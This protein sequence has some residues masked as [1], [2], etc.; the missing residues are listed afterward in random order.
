MGVVTTRR[1]D[2]LR[3]EC[4]K[5]DI[6]WTEEDGRLQL[7]DKLREHLGA[8]DST[9]E[10]D[11]MK[12]KDLKHLIKWGTED[13]FSGIAAYLTDSYVAEPKYD[14]ARLRVFMG[15]TGN[16]I[17]SGRRSVKTFAYTNRTE[18]FPHI[19]NAI[20]PDL[21]GVILDGELLA[22][23]GRI[24]THTGLWTNS[25][26]NASVALCNSNPA[27]SQ[28]TQRR[29]GKARLWVFDVF[30]A[31]GGESMQ[32]LPYTERRAYLETVIATIRAAHP[33]CEIHLVPQLPA[34]VESIVQCLSDGYEG[35]VLKAKSGTYKPGKRGSE[36]CKVKTFSTAD[37]FV[38]GYNDGENG[39]EGLVGS[40]D[41][42]V[43]APVDG[44]VEYEP[45]SIQIVTSENDESFY[46]IPVAQVGNLTMEFRRS[47]SNPDGSLKEAVY[48]TVM[49]FM[50]QGLGKNGRARHAHV[51]RVRPDKD[52]YDCLVDQ[53]D[54]FPAV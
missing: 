24:Q 22:P 1:I 2:Q 41:L 49:E 21:A 10:V 13:P 3:D 18:N 38:V 19:A 26:L 42:A 20:V 33:E 37:A 11:P 50:A 31:A 28:L 53:L 30:A 44:S 25:L 12:A 46:V 23:S 45:R 35:V 47:I 4:D 27:G 17:N 5:A 36:W 9:M 52:K 54:V 15:L 48:D 32:H 7:M 43:L 51:V 34:T 6:D 16:T 29:F 39:N 8:F 14:G 40:L